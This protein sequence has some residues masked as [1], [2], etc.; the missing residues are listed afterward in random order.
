MHDD[1]SL[2]SHHWS[3]LDGAPIYATASKDDDH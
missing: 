3:G 1:E 2:A